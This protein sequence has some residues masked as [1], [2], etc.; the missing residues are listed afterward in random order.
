MSDER[1][2]IVSLHRG[3]DAE[4]FNQEMIAN[5]GAGA[6]PGRSVDVA[7]ARPG[8][9]RNTHYALTDA[10]AEELAKDPRVYGVE[11]PP[12][13]RDDIRP[14]P[15]ALEE[16]NFNKSTSPS[17]NYRDWGKI[18]HSYVADQYNGGTTTSANWPYALDGTGVDVVIQDSG[19]Q[20]DHPEFLDADGNSRVQQINWATESGLPFT[21]SS[22]H[23]RDTDGHGT[24][25]AGT[26]AG[27]NFGWAKN[28]RVYS[29]KVA[30]LEG[31]GDGG[32]GISTTYVFDCI[33]LWHRNK[34]VDPVTGVK[35]PTIVNMSWGY[36]GFYQFNTATDS[37]VYRGT[38]YS[39]TD[40]DTVTKRRAY[41]LPGIS[42]GS[43]GGSPYYRYNSRIASVDTDIQELT[44]EGVH[45]CIAAGNYYYLRDLSTGLDYNNIAFAQV[46][47]FTFGT[48]NAGSFYYHRGGSPYGVDA[49]TVGN[50]NS[51]YTFGTERPADSS[52]K[53]PAVDIYAAGTSILSCTSNTNK[54][55]DASYYGNPVYRQCNISGTS[56]AS[57]Q[58][59]GVGALYLQANPELSP[60]QLKEM[61]AR[62]STKN[63]LNDTGATSYADFDSIMGGNNRILY[64]KYAVQN[65]YT[66]SASGTNVGLSET[67]NQKT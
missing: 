13:Q 1:E 46:Y 38:T 42:Y 2:Y 41:G 3:V 62:D 44:D 6:I 10:E 43:F 23:Y 27:L 65:P 5:T 33:K 30:G 21:Q 54:F 4:Q 39:G 9:Y 32:T 22:N 64:N 37:I 63:E 18:R 29:V 26:A 57:P 47:N 40:T 19:L 8:S 60:V 14:M 50:Q 31:T 20:V 11:I 53:G 24:H 15:F 55:F 66:T 56:M 61:I 51:T 17:G 67:N 28:A 34:P 16:A 52:E 7:D 25:C 35:R 45:V 12:E 49:F 58:V 59:C 48:F 36:G